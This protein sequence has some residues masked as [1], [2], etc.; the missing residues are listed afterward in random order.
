M[1]KFTAIASGTLTLLVLG[2]CASGPIPNLP[3]VDVS[4]VENGKLLTAAEVYAAV[5]GR[6]MVGD[7]TRGNGSKI[8]NLQYV[9]EADG[10]LRGAWMKGGDVGRW[11][12]DQNTGDLC[13]TWIRENS[14]CG[15]SSVRA[16]K[17]L[18]QNPRTG[19]QF[20]QQ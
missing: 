2:G 9:F 17:L 14:A 18:L 1:N 11:H 7:I 12:V 20:L 13:T 3:M 8:P 19:G 15:K 6:Q 5:R 10:T 4:K 16:G